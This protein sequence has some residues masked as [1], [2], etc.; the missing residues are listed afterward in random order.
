MQLLPLG[1]K[2]LIVELSSGSPS[3]LAV[4]ARTHPVYQREAERA[5]EEERSESGQVFGNFGLHLL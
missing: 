5:L 4:L 2:H 3:S 1:L